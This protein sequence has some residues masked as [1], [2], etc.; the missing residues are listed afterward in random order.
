M[1]N[2]P[3]R[4][5]S[6]QPVSEQQADIRR[7]SELRELVTSFRR[8]RDRHMTNEA[9]LALLKLK[10]AGIRAFSDH[11]CQFFGEAASTSNARLS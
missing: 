1:R 5:G 6:P 3:G 2:A 9:H 11:S 8:S 10:L 7:A 4:S